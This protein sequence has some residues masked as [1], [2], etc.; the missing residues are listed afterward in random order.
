[1]KYGLTFAESFEAADKA[2]ALLDSERDAEELL[3]LAAKRRDRLGVYVSEK[4][5]AKTVKHGVI[6]LV[7]AQRAYAVRVMEETLQI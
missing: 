4:F 1:M 3:L 6:M 5:P 7:A 2:L